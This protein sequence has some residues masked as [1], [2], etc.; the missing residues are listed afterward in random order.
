MWES[1]GAVLRD[2]YREN[3]GAFQRAYLSLIRENPGVFL[4]A[5]MQTFV[6]TNSLGG[7]PSA[8][9]RGKEMIACATCHAELPAI[10][11]RSPEMA[12][13]DQDTR[14]AVVRAFLLVDANNQDVPGGQIVWN[15]IPAL[16]LL[17]LLF[18]GALVRRKLFVAAIAAG[19]LARTAIVFATAPA[20]FFMYYQST[21]AIAFALAVFVAVYWIDQRLASK[22]ASSSARHSSASTPA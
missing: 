19:L 8:E 15:V 21:Y 2:G 6:A 1:E 5:R 17:L 4:E 13:I 20:T 22:K 11:D 10:I 7:I 9:V 18:A 14:V 12:A 16:G 3:A